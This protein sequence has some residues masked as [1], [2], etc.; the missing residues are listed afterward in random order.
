MNIVNRNSVADKAD[1]VA[2]PSDL[3]V[4]LQSS[5]LLSL[6]SVGL[7]FLALHEAKARSVNHSDTPQRETKVT[8]I[9]HIP[10]SPSAEVLPSTNGNIEVSERGQMLR[11]PSG[12]IL[13]GPKRFVIVLDANMH[14]RQVLA[15]EK[16]TA[17]LVLLRLANE[18]AQ[19]AILS[20]GPQ[21]H[22][23]GALTNDWKALAGFTQSV[24]V[25]PDHS[26]DSILTFDAVKHALEILDRESGTKA[27]VLFAEGND[28]GSSEGWKSLARLAESNNVACYVVLFANHTFYGA[29]AIRHYGWD[30]LE[31]TAKT[32][33]K[34][35]EVGQSDQKAGRVV[36]EIES[37]IDSQKLIEVMTNSGTPGRF[38]S[39]RITVSGKRVSAQTGYFE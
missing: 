22:A 39:L 21:V 15:L 6:L 24:E 13:G 25:D 17:E 37:E 36:M 14:Q 30:L 38:H 10:G 2:V 33:G 5:S 8:L 11:V 26:G 31:L 29:K 34:F 32:G 27:L 20:Y 28:R 35:W 1:L 12:P 7:L 23:S 19:G 3:P 16:K 4:S 9:V 18:K